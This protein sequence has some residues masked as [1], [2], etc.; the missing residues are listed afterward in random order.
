M[1]RVAVVLLAGCT[2]QLDD[3][4]VPAELQ[5]STLDGLLAGA[6]SRHAGRL[7]MTVAGSV[8]GDPGSGEVAAA[9]TLLFGGLTFQ[10]EGTFEPGGRGL[11]LGGEGFALTGLGTADGIVGASVGPAGGGQFVALREG[12]ASRRLCGTLTRPASGTE[13]NFRPQ[14]DG[15]LGLLATAQGEVHAVYDLGSSGGSAIGTLSGSRLSIPTSDGGNFTGTLL[16]G[17]VDGTFSVDGEDGTFVA[18]EGAC[19]GD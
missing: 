16:E 11:L 17:T 6:G 3:P 1:L 18:V 10:L 12:L 13:P 14:F 15:G 8:P 2:P 5:E 4:Y 19:P 7:A 9:A